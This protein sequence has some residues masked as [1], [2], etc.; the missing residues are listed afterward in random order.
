MAYRWF[1]GLDLDERVPDNSTISQNRRRQFGGE[2][3]FGRLFEHILH[4]C[5][6]KG[7][8]DG[9]LIL[10]DSTHVKANASFYA[11][12]KVLAEHETT[13][14]M[15]RLDR[16]E[17]EERK[18]LEDSRAIKLQRTGKVKKE[19]KRTEKTI[20]TTDRGAGMLKR[21]GKPEGMHYLS[22]QSVDAAHGIEWMWQ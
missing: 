4:L 8:V 18:R 9:R 11:N 14:Y 3:L 6:E 2:N 19:R 12:V 15:E 21:P 16:Y 13:D 17:A 22:H 10:T 20:N 7:L 5:M 1:L